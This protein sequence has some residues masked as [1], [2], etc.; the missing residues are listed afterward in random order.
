MV[1]SWHILNRFCPDFSPFSAM[2]STSG[3]S[4]GGVTGSGGPWQAR[5]HVS[6]SLY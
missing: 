2:M 4:A 5:Q 6:I 3:G 1:G